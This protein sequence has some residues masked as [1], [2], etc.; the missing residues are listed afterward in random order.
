M[1]CLFC[2]IAEKRVPAS[3]VYEDEDTLAFLD[4]NPMAPG[5]TLIIPKSHAETILDL[6]EDKLGLLIEAV[7]SV[8][9]LIFESL[10][11]S[12]FTWG[13]NQGKISG[14]EVP[15]LH[16]HLV[17]R[18]PGDGGSSFQGLVKNIPKESI[19]EIAA[20]INPKNG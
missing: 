18:F 3:V 16:I 10:K 5:H 11:P 2:S 14:Q 8:E 20:K 9:K 1:S 17:P 12:G 15:H 19:K 13:V 7:A 4:V 6:E